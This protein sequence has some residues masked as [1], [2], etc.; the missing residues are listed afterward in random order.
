MQG[1]NIHFTAM[2]FCLWMYKFRKV[3]GFNCRTGDPP[4]WE[5]PI[6]RC[7]VHINWNCT[8][9]ES[10]AVLLK[11]WIKDDK[12]TI[13]QWKRTS[14]FTVENGYVG[15]LEQYNENGLILN[16]LTTKDAGYYKLVVIF[17]RTDS[18]IH[19]EISSFIYVPSI[20]SCEAEIYM[21]TN[22]SH[23]NGGNDTKQVS[24]CDGGQIP[25]F[26]IGILGVLGILILVIS[27]T[28]ICLCRKQKLLQ[29][30][31]GEMHNGKGKELIPLSSVPG[32][33]V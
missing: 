19:E 25:A 21:G 3:D 7:T 12:D 5:S 22:S 31:L 33:P 29:N 6:K 28:V 9:S 4:L 32:S 16:G 17:N 1:S 23:L 2:V 26:I 13:A 11:T 15:R 20:P 14:D 27:S 8:Q 30:D 18:L 24:P 10:E